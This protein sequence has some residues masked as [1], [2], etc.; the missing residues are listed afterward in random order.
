MREALSKFA[1]KEAFKGKGALSVAL[2]ITE[3]A[4]K[5]SFPLDE[6]DFLAEKGTQVSGLGGP[7]VAAILKRHGIQRVLAAEGGRTSRGSVNNMR[8]YV[9]FLNTQAKATSFDLK[10]AERFWI[11]RVKDFFAGKP[12]TLR[13][14]AQFSLRAVVK[15]LME[16]A[17]TRQKQGSGTRFM[18]T[19][20]QHLVGAKLE[21][22]MGPDAGLVHHNSNQSDQKPGRTGDFDIGDVSI[23]VSTAPTESLIKKCSANIAA[24][25]KPMIITGRKGL[26]LAEGLA[27]NAGISAFVDMI[28]FEQFIAT[29]VH[30]LGKFKS[31]LR[32][33]KLD[34]I[35]AKYNEIV[36]EHETDPSLCIE[37]ASGKN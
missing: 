16:Q 32:R 6:N 21:V 20:M 35:V 25:R 27:E 34:E 8:A 2:V 36:A 4:K 7:P 15:N 11:E 30:E 14:D 5:R 19:V 26:L 24:G 9:A 1:K 37:I 3:Q 17:E 31:S 29:N 12:F 13:I 33:I 28:E 22:F 10:I 18:G 23:H